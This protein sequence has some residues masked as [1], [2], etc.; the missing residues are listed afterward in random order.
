MVKPK[1]WPQAASL[2]RRASDVLLASAPHTPETFDLHA[3][4]QAAADECDRKDHVDMVVEQ[5]AQTKLDIPTLRERKSDSHDFHEVS[6][7]G[8]KR[9]LAAA[10]EAGQDDAK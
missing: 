10:Y 5:I 1:A 9:A 3:K 8:L 7:W 4:Y 6:V 2:W